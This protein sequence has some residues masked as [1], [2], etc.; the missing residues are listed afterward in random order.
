MTEDRTIYDIPE[1][2]F[3]KF[4]RE[5][6]KLSRKSERLIGSAITPVLFSHEMIE[7]THGIRKVYQVY[8]NAESPCLAG[9]T[10]VARIDHSQDTGNIIRAIPN[11]GVDLPEYLRSVAPNCDHCGAKRRRRDTFVIRNDETGDFQQVGSTC[12]EDFFGH[13][14][15]KIA[16]LAEYLGYANEISRA[17]EESTGLQDHRYVNSEEFMAY[18]A[19]AVRKNGWVS[20]KAARENFGMVSTRDAAMCLKNTGETPSDDDHVLAAKAAEWGQSLAENPKSDYEHNVA[21]IANA[22][23]IEKRSLGLAA[24]IVG[25]FHDN[26]RRNAGVS[27]ANTGKLDGLVSL[28]TKAK[29]RFPKIRMTFDEGKPLAISLAGSSSKNPGSVYLTDGGPFGANVYYGRVAPDGVF[30][31]SK[32]VSPQSM[33]ALASVL[34]ALSTNSAATAA[35]YGRL[36]GRCCFC[37]LPLNNHRST[38]VGYGETC[39]KT[40]GLP[41]G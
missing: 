27:A 37:N 6:A 12:L 10:F 26:A 25:V 9:W 24:S 3:A 39:A 19:M 30:F 22:A 34:N 35:K 4:E 17:S 33:T 7:S 13:D 31:P 18:C 41:W 38:A 21:V 5:I 15:Y 8:L 11:L 16:R 1:E 40:Y 14:P 20:A 29:S 2:N 32:A 28:L 36:T 23:F